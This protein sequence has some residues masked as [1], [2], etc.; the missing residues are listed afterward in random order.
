MKIRCN[1]HVASF[2]RVAAIDGDK[3]E[4]GEKPMSP[5][6][7]NLHGI[8]SFV[9]DYPLR[10]EVS[11]PHLVGESWSAVDILEMASK[12]YQTIYAAE[13]AAVGP[14]ANIPGM[15]NRQQSEGPYGI[16]G[17]DISDLYF[18]EIEIN[19]ANKIISFG[20]GS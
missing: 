2:D 17:H 3:E 13:D 10:K 15:L 18:E 16:W 7:L 14:T 5:T 11:I 19:E 8:F 9:Y 4:F 20:I 12:D 1:H 6:P